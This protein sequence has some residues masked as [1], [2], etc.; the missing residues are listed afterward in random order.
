MARE[1]YQVFVQGDCLVKS[2]RTAEMVKL[3]ENAFRDVNIAFANELAFV[4]ERLGIEVL[5]LIALA[6]RH[7]RVKILRPDPG[8]GGRC[9]PVDP[10]FIVGSVDGNARLIQ[11][12]REVNDSRPAYII[13][14]VKEAATEFGSPKIACF[15]LAYN[16]DV[17]DLRES[18][19]VEIVRPL[20]VEGVG[21]IFVVE[22][23]IS[24]LPAS[25]TGLRNIH[26][27]EIHDALRTADIVV[28]LADHRAFRSIDR[29]MLRDKVVVDT[30]GMW[31]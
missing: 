23:Y 31:L 7:P 15:G 10:W 1:L 30:R 22:P 4:C 8:V 2:I 11:T 27:G 9:I 29:E 16:A 5:E 6:N 13:G 12:A 17:D 18:P 24:R 28:G 20:S 26:L 25:L 14:K 21:E 3:A 19:A